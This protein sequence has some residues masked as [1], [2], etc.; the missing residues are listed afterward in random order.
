M[1]SPEEAT[2][3]A[4]MAS[5]AGSC[6]DQLGLGMAMMASRVRSCYGREMTT[7]PP[8][9]GPTGSDLTATAQSGAPTRKRRRCRR[10]SL[11]WPRRRKEI[12]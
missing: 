7:T 3:M 8:T 4:T 10:C 12:N 9:G 1:I 2:P 5:G 11:C 6:Y